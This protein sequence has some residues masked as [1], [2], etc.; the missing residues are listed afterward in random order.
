MR[1]E[2]VAAWGKVA[3]GR[4]IW[5]RTTFAAVVNSKHG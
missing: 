5:Y 1:F 2:Q 4:S 3:D